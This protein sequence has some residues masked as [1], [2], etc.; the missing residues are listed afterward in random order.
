MKFMD[1]I[2]SRFRVACLEITVIFGCNTCVQYHESCVGSDLG[3]A[4][5]I[6]KCLWAKKAV[7]LT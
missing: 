3:K 6:V 5:E 7:D 1:S 2:D 4:P